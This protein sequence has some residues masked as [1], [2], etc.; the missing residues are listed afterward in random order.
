MF[1]KVPWN[2]LLPFLNCR[3]Q[4]KPSPLLPATFS[5]HWLAKS[6]L[7]SSSPLH[8]H[9]QNAQNDKRY[10]MLDAYQNKFCVDIFHHRKVR[11]LSRHPVPHPPFFFDR[12]DKSG[13][14]F[15]SAKVT[16][17]VPPLQY[18][19]NTSYL[20]NPHTPP[21]D[22]FL[23]ITAQVNRESFLQASAL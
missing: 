17:E 3:Q 20:F 4:T 8:P 1:T 9:N 15:L 18:W 16:Q 11:I 10:W 13:P 2:I 14:K 12:V 22:S 19:L 23:E 6:S 7:Y 5:F 21:L